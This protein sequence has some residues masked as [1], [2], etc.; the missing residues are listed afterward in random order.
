[1]SLEDWNLRSGFFSRQWRTIRSRPGEMFWLVTASSGGS[2]LRID[3]IVSPAESPWN[4]RFPESI[5]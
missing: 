2:S 1:M 3:A 5:S 4:A